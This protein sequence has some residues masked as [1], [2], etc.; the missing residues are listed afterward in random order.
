MTCC[1]SLSMNKHYFIWY[2]CKSHRILQFYSTLCLVF[3]FFISIKCT[4][5]FFFFNLI[6]HK[7][8]D[9]S[10][11]NSVYT[12]VFLEVICTQRPHLLLLYTLSCS[13]FPKDSLIPLL[14][15]TSIK[16]DICAA[17][18]GEPFQVDHVFYL[19]LT[20]HFC[21]HHYGQLMRDLLSSQLT[22]LVVC[23]LSPQELKGHKSL[24]LP[25]CCCQKHADSWQKE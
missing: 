12:C 23:R 16:N 13:P 19:D 9:N 7:Q 21:S 25:S 15:I 11:S 4:Q 6:T 14:W 18:H 5:L 17:D 20:S 22:G 3:N 8:C 1:W 2:I 10:S 24:L